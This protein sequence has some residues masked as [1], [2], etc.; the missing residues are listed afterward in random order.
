MP[1]TSPNAPYQTLTQYR[2]QRHIP[3]EI[4]SPLHISGG[5]GGRYHY[6]IYAV[7][8]CS[9]PLAALSQ[10]TPPSP[11]PPPLRGPPLP[12]PSPPLG[13]ERGTIRRLVFF[14]ATLGCHVHPD[15]RCRPVRTNAPPPS[16]EVRVPLYG[17]HRLFSELAHDAHTHM[18]IRCGTQTHTFHSFRYT[19]KIAKEPKEPKER[20]AWASSCSLKLSKRAG[21]THTGSYAKLTLTLPKFRAKLAQ[22][23]SEETDAKANRRRSDV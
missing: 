17:R 14:N 2:A 12:L 19:D 15:E 18:V 9:S 3:F 21:Y 8:P 22:C 20:S 7:V 16:G 11:T 23:T 6:C 5:M 1:T 10:P 4:V 13:G